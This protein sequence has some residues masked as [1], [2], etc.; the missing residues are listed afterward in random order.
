MARRYNENLVISTQLDLPGLHLLNNLCD[1]E[2][3]QSIHAHNA[4]LH[5]QIRLAGASDVMFSAIIY[6]IG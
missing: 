3:S 2:A 4:C 6:V 1:A 5:E